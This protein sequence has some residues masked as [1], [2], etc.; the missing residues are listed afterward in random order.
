MLIRQCL[1]VFFFGFTASLCA[2]DRSVD[3]VYALGLSPDASSWPIQTFYT[4]GNAPRA[5]LTLPVAGLNFPLDVEYRERL[6]SGTWGPLPT[7]H[8]E[9]GADSL[10]QSQTGEATFSFPGVSQ[11]FIRFK[12]RP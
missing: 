10:E 7:V 6:D 4:S 8:F 9:S 2:V 11:G 3:L 5:E 1:F 12:V